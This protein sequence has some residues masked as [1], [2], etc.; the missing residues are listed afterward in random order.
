MNILNLVASRIKVFKF[1]LSFYSSRWAQIKAT[2]VFQMEAVYLI[3]TGS[4]ISEERGNSVAG[5]VLITHSCGRL[6]S[7]S[8]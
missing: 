4:V 5:G 8:W 3:D 7:E 1:V 6:Q 2:K